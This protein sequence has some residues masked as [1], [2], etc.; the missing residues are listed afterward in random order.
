MNSLWKEKNLIEQWPNEN[1][2]KI[3][4]LPVWRTALQKASEERQTLLDRAAWNSS[5]E[6]MSLISLID[7]L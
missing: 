3:D 5:I 7:N 6:L 4:K 2:L 1:K